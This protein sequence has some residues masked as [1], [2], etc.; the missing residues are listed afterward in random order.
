MV[1]NKKC[2]Y[3]MKFVLVPAT[4]CY[5]LPIF[6]M[7]NSICSKIWSL[8]FQFS[9]METPNIVHYFPHS[10]A[11]RRHA[12]LAMNG[13]KLAW[14]KTSQVTLWPESLYCVPKVYIFLFKIIQIMIK[15]TYQKHFFREKC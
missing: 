12:F 7:K 5:W 2:Y 6:Q 1:R 15:Y 13:R 4:L 8:A 3:A 10:H 9:L 14:A 11:W